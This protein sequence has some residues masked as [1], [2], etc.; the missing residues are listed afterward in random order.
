M[1]KMERSLSYTHIISEKPQKTI[2]DNE[3]W[4]TK[5]EIEFI[6][7]SV[8]Y[9]PDTEIVLKNLN[10]H[11]NSGEHV[12]IVG[13]T[14]SGKSTIA[15]C[16]FRILEAYE[17][18]IVIDGI[19]I[20]TLGLK[21]LRSSLTIIPQDATIMDGTLRYNIDPIG[22]FT[23][24][25]IVNVMNKIG[26]EYI[27]HNHPE[28]LSQNISENGSNLSIGEKQ[29]ICFVRAA[30]KKSKV[31]ILDEATSSMD[32]QTEKIIQNNINEHLKD[33]TII[34]IAHHIQMVSACQRIIVIDKG[35]I[36]E[37][38]SYEKLMNDK[39][40]KFYELYSE[41]LIS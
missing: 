24:Q 25:N 5:G 36:V 9:R 29:L 10:I 23:D 21:K 17:G 38:D 27:I 20:S 11:I 35:E 19:D 3:T 13:R 31:I 33:C 34:M 26:F 37:C 22:Q 40:S 2:N 6:D 30:L 8:R 32:V 15:L 16:L 41:S 4:P 39:K 7:Y 18:K 12:G 28:G 1:T 14:G